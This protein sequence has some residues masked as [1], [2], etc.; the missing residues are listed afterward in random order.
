MI[1]TSIRIDEETYEKITKL[2]NKDKR[3]INSEIIYLLEKY[4]KLE[5]K[6]KN[7]E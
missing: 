7:N 6:E 1:H 5:E 3:S 2:A 4:I